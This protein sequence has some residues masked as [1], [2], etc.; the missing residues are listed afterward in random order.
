[1]AVGREVT[2]E[3]PARLIPRARQIHC[4]EGM[5]YFLE[6]DLVREAIEVW[7]KWRNGATPTLDE[8]VAAVIYYG[9][10]DAYLP[11]EPS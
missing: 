2:G 9:E 1:M 10:Q 5:R 8:A 7:S 4:P 11:C 6:V 3:I